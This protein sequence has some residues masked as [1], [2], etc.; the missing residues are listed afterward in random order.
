MEGEIIFYIGIVIIRINAFNK[1]LQPGLDCL[2]NGL[3][4]A[5]EKTVGIAA[6]GKF[7]G[8]NMLLKLLIDVP[9]RLVSCGNAEIFIDQPEIFYI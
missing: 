5:E 6:G 7:S 1:L 9:E 8:L 4:Q 3:Q 2:R